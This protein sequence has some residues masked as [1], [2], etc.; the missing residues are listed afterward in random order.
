M[1]KFTLNLVGEKSYRPYRGEI[2]RPKENRDHHEQQSYI[3]FDHLLDSIAEKGGSSPYGLKASDLETFEVLAGMH[4]VELH[5]TR[6]NG[7]TMLILIPEE[8]Q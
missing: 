2:L 8:S 1:G 4:N 6:A 5:I 3:V 7:A